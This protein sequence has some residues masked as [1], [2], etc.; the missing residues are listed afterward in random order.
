MKLLLVSESPL[1]KRGSDYFAVDP[2]I[3]IPGFWSESFADVTVLSPVRVRSDDWVP[4]PS[5]WKVN[6]GHMRV[7]HHEYYFRW[8]QYFRLLPRWYWRWMR[9]LTRLASE[10]DVVVLRAPAPIGPLVARSAAAAG[11]P[12]IAFMLADIETQPTPLVQAR[13]LKR[14]LYRAVVSYLVRQER[15]IVGQCALVYAYS[16]DLLR[17]YGDLGVRVKYMQDPHLKERDLRLREDTCAQPVVRLL[18]IC[19]LLPSKGVESL[20]DAVAVLVRRGAPV[21][22]EIVGQER[23]TG[24]KQSLIGYAARLGLADAVTFSDW[25]PFD[26]VLDVYWRSDIQIISSLGEGTP[27]CIVEGFAC[28]LPLVSTDS[29]GCRDALSHEQNALLV[30]VGDAR[31][32][33]DAVERLIRDGELRRRVIRGGY[34]Y[35]HAATFDA[36]EAEMAAD[37]RSVV[38]G[39]STG[40]RRAV[41]EPLV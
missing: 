16:K 25:V 29:G 7:E 15:W 35:A 28:G 10:H 11:K 30:P 13:G 1:D 4:P 17:R 21:R 20:L 6:L 32:M 40:R 39:P 38:P 27:R 12:L 24:Y 41:P 8:S 33:A 3:R 26:R 31:A 5:A 9:K 23:D 2:W 19:W 36:I 37:F 14:L 22:L 34:A 18:R